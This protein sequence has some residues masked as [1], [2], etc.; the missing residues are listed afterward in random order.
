MAL[1]V[2][3][4][5]WMARLPRDYPTFGNYA[6]AGRSSSSIQVIKDLGVLEN[7]DVLIEIRRAVGIAGAGGAG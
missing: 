5:V 3:L 4:S 1:L 7:Y 2:A 6:G